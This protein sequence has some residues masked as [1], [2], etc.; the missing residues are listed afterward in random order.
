MDRHYNHFLHHPPPTTTR[1]L[2]KSF[3]CLILSTLPVPYHSITY[4]LSHDPYLPP[5]PWPPPTTFTP[6]PFLPSLIL[7]LSFPCLVT[8]LSLSCTYNVPILSLSWPYLVSVFSFTCYPY[9]LKPGARPWSL[10]SC[11]IYLLDIIKFILHICCM[12][13]GTF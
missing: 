11:S 9:P 6:P 10:A 13:L 2:F 8:V 12:V 7:S 3:K 5:N 1:K 4:P